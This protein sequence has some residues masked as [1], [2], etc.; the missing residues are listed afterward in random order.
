M[1]KLKAKSPISDAEISISQLKKLV[2]D[3]VEDRKWW[4][5]HTPKNL[6]ISISIEAAE[7]LEHFQWFEKGK[8]T[9][10]KADL[11]MVEEELSD[12]LAYIL[13]LSNVLDIDIASAIHRK[14]HLNAKK[15]PTE[16]FQGNWT[17]AGKLPDFGHDAVR[18]RPQ[19]L[20]VSGNRKVKA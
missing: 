15:Y 5:F 12:V 16:K 4:K 17:K 19:R 9:L 8:K 7:L 18:K 13:S 1:P 14:M 10:T 11:Q 3:F 2:F 20:K 6:A